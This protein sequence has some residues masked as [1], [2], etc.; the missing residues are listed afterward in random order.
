MKLLDKY[1][2]V[3]HH[4]DFYNI[5]TVDQV[6]TWGI[7]LGWD[8]LSKTEKDRKMLSC[9]K[10]I[11]TE[12]NDGPFKY[13]INKILK[14]SQEFENKVIFVHCREPKEI[15]KIKCKMNE[16]NIFCKTILVT[17]PSIKHIISNHAD[18]NVLNYEYDYN[19]VNDGTLED[20][21]N[22]A[23]EIFGRLEWH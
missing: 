9:L 5:S 18:A 23:L 11:S 17:R 6:K 21:R 3:L 7:E 12:Y 15:E 8:G 2:A 4:I 10:D 13:T 19:I 1:L 22:K 14:I 20:L 16:L